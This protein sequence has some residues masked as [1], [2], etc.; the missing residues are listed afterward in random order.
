LPITVTL[1]RDALD[2]T[3][4]TLRQ[5]IA[6][7]EPFCVHYMPEVRDFYRTRMQRLQRA[8]AMLTKG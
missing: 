5:G 3:C 4:D 2:C 7:C 8:L 6:E 1:D